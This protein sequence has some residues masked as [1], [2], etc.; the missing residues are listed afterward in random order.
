MGEDERAAAEGIEN[1]AFDGADGDLSARHTTRG[2]E[3]ERD[4][5]DST[6]AAQEQKKEPQAPDKPR[7]NECARNYF[8]PPMAEE[9]NPRQCRME[10]GTEDELELKLM[11]E[12]E[13]ELYYMMAAMLNEDD[14]TTTIDLPGTMPSDE[15]AEVK[16]EATARGAALLPAPPGRGRVTQGELIPCYVERLKECVQGDMIA[17]GSL[18]LEQMPYLIHATSISGP[19]AESQLLKALSKRKGEVM[20]KY[21]TM[22]EVTALSDREQ[23]LHWQVEWSRTPQPVEIHLLCLRAV[24]DKLPRGHYALTAALHCRL[25]GRALRW[26]RLKGSP[27]AGDHRSRGAPGPLPRHG[28]AP[29]SERL[30]RK[31]GDRPAAAQ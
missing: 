18:S 17:L 20:A 11:R 16:M 19:K 24:R 7:G 23:G 21:G 22:T 3:I 10:V 4:K 15:R 8:D 27:W 25:G 29:R 9:T 12:G 30:H 28:A 13:E 31:L 1:P 2:R 26:S 5:Q 6:L 14:S